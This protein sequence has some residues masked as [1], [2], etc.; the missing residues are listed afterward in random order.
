MKVKVWYFDSNNTILQD[1]KFYEVEAVTGLEGGMVEIKQRDKRQMIPQR[2]LKR[3][4]IHED[5]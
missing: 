1:D 3:L 2:N 5:A 4:E